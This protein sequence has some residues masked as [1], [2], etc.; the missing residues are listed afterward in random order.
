[1]APPER[2]LPKGP[3]RV[4]SA[5]SEEMIPGSECPDPYQR[6]WWATEGVPPHQ[7]HSA[8][9]ACW[10]VIE[11]PTGRYSNIQMY[12]LIAPLWATREGLTSCSRRRI[13]VY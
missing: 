1:L 3:V 11:S 6:S 4:E 8:A 7:L 9:W 2:S 12:I 13:I 10:L 5:K